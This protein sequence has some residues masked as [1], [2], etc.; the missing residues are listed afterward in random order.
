MTIRERSKVLALEV[1][2]LALVP[3]KEAACGA[4]I[5]AAGEPLAAALHMLLRGYEP[6]RDKEEQIKERLWAAAAALAAWEAR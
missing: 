2:C 1:D 3:D 4:A 6:D 5:R